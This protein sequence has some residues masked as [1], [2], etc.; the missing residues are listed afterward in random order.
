M[1]SSAAIEEPV[2]VQ[3]LS[4]DLAKLDVKEIIDH[5]KYTKNREIDYGEHAPDSGVSVIKV[6]KEL[7]G[8]V[9]NGADVTG[10]NLPASVLDPMSSLE[11]GAKAMQR[12]ET[13]CDIVE[14][15]N[16]EL[17]FLLVFMYQLAGLPKERF[18]KKPY[19]PILGEVFRAC[20]R[21]KNGA[22]TMLYAEQVSH[23]P[24]ITAVHLH[25]DKLGI[26]FNSYMKPEPKFWGNSIEVRLTGLIKLSLE[27][28]GEV[29]EM[30]RPTIWQTGILGIGKQRVE[31][32][33]ETT[34][35]C[36]KNDLIGNF[37]FKAKGLLGMRGEANLV[38]GTV[39]Q[40]STGK[41]LYEING[42]WDKQV[43]VKEIATKKEWVLFDYE[44]CKEEKSMSMYVPP[45]E[46]LEPNNSLIVWSKCS[47]AIWAEDT[48]KAN[49]EKKRVEDTQRVLRKQREEKGEK[50]LP[51]FF[52][53][54]E[55]GYQFKEELETKL[56][57]VG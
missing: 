2:D 42:T 28:Y 54:T 47:E 32:V 49:E 39:K 46:D 25:S 35:T 51:M 17:R 23:H 37:E 6:A 41:T 16:P 12:G 21:H 31:F 14:E 29:Y 8:S 33:G 11:K 5:H 45:T 36:E 38:T 9:K 3:V 44:Q 50:W 10:V 48:A 19:N 52:N 22:I 15:T 43:K 1:S 13:L 40:K 34:L 4:G 24:P 7:L 30:T 18:G 20:F 27:K 55:D 26:C 57:Y 53:P 56:A